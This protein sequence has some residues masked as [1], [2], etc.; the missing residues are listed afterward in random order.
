MVS[1]G[2]RNAFPFSVYGDGRMEISEND[3]PLFPLNT[4]LFPQARLAL[5]IFEARYREM[6]ERCLRENLAF[7]VVLIKEGV[8]VGG[9]ATPHAVGTLAHIVDVERLA[10]GRMNIVVK[11]LERFKLLH[12]SRARSYLTGQIELLHDENEGTSEIG[13]AKEQAARLFEVYLTAVQS[14]S[15]SER[16]ENEG[17][18]DLPQDPVVLSYIIASI[19]PINTRDKQMLL[20]IPTATVRLR[21]EIPIIQ[22]EMQLLHLITE[23]R[24]RAVDQGSFSLN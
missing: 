11:G 13:S 14:L 10:D 5:Q 23:S 3:L 4:V 24:D 19:L 1:W 12:Q 21:R 9:D 6:I 15:Q 17:D 2:R 22:R 18:L 20:E 7:G 16:N 8:E